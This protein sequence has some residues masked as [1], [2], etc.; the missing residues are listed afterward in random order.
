MVGQSLGLKRS[1]QP[2]GGLIPIFTLESGMNSAT[3]SAQYTNALFGRHA[4][5]G[6]SSHRCGSPADTPRTYRRRLLVK[7]TNER[8]RSSYEI[9]H[10]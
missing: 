8:R 6:L 10:K 2:G 4:W 7:A 1:E 5:L 3:G 9:L